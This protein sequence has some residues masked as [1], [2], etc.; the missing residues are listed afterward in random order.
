MEGL[1][2]RS[3]WMENLLYVGMAEYR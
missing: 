1:K 2:L 3:K